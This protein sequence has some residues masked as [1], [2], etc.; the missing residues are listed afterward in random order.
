[1]YPHPGAVC[2][3]HTIQAK[4]ACALFPENYF[5]AN[6]QANTHLPSIDFIQHGLHLHAQ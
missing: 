1:M 4:F 5:S 2:Y 3:F 6:T